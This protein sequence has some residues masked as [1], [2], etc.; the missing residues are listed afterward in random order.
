MV[1]CRQLGY[2]SLGIL[3][4]NFSKYLVSFILGSISIGY[5]NEYNLPFRIIDLNCT[6]HEA[7]IQDCPSNGLDSY[8]CLSYHDAAVACHST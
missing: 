6:G 5:I 7:T 4:L 2:T 8:R 3:T 1:V